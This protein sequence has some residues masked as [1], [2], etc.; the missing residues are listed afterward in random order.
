MGDTARCPFSRNLRGRVRGSASEPFPDW[1]HYM[2]L[3]EVDCLAAN[4]YT[5]LALQTDEQR[6]WQHCST[7][8]EL[9]S[10][11]ARHSRGEGYVHSRI[12]D[13]IRLAKVRLP[14]R[15]PA[16]V[17]TVALHALE[18][19]E[20]PRSSLVVDWLIRF[21]Q[22]LGE[23]YPDQAETTSF[24]DDLRQYV[25]KAALLRIGELT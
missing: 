17:A 4:A 22:A 15:E 14:Q 9:R 6:T 20:D 1:L 8:A 13:E 10:L 5:E 24:N 21:D 18:L 11:R 16:E 2:N 25:R 12:F 3:A 19:A 7:K 23:R